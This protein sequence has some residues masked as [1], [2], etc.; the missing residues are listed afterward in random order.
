[1]IFKQIL[2]VFDI[3]SGFFIFIFP[4]TKMM[5]TNHYPS[6]RDESLAIFLFQEILRRMDQF[7][8]K[9]HSK[10][11][12]DSADVKQHYNLSDSTLYRLRRNNLIKYFKLGGKYYYSIKSIEDLLK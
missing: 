1:M 8:L 5:K 12:M 4:N 6:N 3:L 2:N 10:P 11:F 9:A 7:S